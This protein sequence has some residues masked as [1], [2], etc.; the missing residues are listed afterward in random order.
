VLGLELRELLASSLPLLPG[1]YLVLRHSS[2]SI[3]WLS[4]M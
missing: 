1:S 3:V 2:A 4:A